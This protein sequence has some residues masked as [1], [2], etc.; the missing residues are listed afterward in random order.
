[1][2]VT[3][4]GSYLRAVGTPCSWSVAHTQTRAEHGH[5]AYNAA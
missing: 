4:N 3:T 2:V 1:M 5:V